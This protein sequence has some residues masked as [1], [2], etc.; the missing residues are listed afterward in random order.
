MSQSTIDPAEPEVTADQE[1][2]Q[3]TKPCRGRDPRSGVARTTAL[4]IA[5][6]ILAV[7]DRGVAPPGIGIVAFG[8]IPRRISAGV[9]LVARV[10]ARTGILVDR[11]I[12]IGARVRIDLGNSV[13]ARYPAALEGEGCIEDVLAVAERC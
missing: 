9:D 13:R 11:G 6:I 7:G 12:G 2:P 4:L 5:R 1:H 8:G 10:G 3:D